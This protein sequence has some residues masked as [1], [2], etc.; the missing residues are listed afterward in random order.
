MAKKLN[1]NL[2][3]DPLTD[4]NELVEWLKAAST[5]HISSAER[6][7]GRVRIDGDLA[8]QLLRYNWN[9]RQCVALHLQ[10]MITDASVG[11]FPDMPEPII[12]VQYADTG[13]TFVWDG[14]TRLHT[15]AQHEKG[16]VF[17][18]D[19]LVMDREQE[20]MRRACEAESRRRS[21]NDIIAELGLKDPCLI[22]A[23][24]LYTSPHERRR[25]QISIPA[26]MEE[27]ERYEVRILL[28]LHVVQ[29]SCG[30]EDAIN[31]KRVL[32]TLAVA[33]LHCLEVEPA[34]AVEFFRMFFN[35]V[36]LAA[37][38]PVKVLRQELFLR[39][40]TSGERHHPSE[41]GSLIRRVFQ[42]FSDQS[43][44]PSSVSGFSL[45]KIGCPS[46]S[47]IALLERPEENLEAYEALSRFLIE[48]LKLAA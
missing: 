45:S 48:P 33:L 15:A 9:N 24:K 3:T 16:L 6:F 28:A 31:F 14:Q 10:K 26:L 23:A 4:R 21:I 8:R 1:L 34:K 13:E 7:S 36:D 38:H 22:D 41:L 44:L 25:G 32:P 35:P 20:R 37:F 18:V 42:W 29:Q 12:F 30:S 40:A 19:V 47:K 5:E 43:E 46:L 17:N 39:V 11:R 27:V 2:S